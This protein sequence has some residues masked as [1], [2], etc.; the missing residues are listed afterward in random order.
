ML[1]HYIGDNILIGS[2]EKEVMNTLDAFVRCV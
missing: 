1:I 2:G